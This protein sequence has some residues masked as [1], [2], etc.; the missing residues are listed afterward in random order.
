MGIVSSR[1]TRSAFS[2][3]PVPMTLRRIGRY[4]PFVDR[5]VEYKITQPVY[6]LMFKT[7]FVQTKILNLLTEFRGEQFTVRRRYETELEVVYSYINTYTFESP[8]FQ[9]D[10]GVT[11]SLQDYTY[12]GRRNYLVSLSSRRQNLMPI[13]NQALEEALTEAQASYEAHVSERNSLVAL[14]LTGKDNT[15]RGEALEI[16]ARHY[17]PE[18]IRSVVGERANIDSSSPRVLARQYSQAL[19]NPQV[20]EVLFN[21]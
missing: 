13:A 1:Q 17:Y 11:M 4:I 10:N 12:Q 2:W 19:R 15:R 7:S 18:S 3:R 16:F 20:D 21:R 5:D 6:D 9:G 8:S 14:A